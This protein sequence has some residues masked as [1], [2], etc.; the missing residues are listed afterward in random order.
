MSGLL[1]S[2]ALEGDTKLIARMQSWP[3]SVQASLYQ[4]VLY[5]SLKLEAYIKNSKLNG[6]VLKRVSGALA[7]SITSKVEQTAMTVIGVVFSSGDVKYAAIQE[8][9]GTTLAHIIRPKTASVLAWG[10]PKAFAAFVMHP[11]SHMPERSYM[12]S[13]LN[14]MSQEISTGLKQAAV[15]GLMKGAA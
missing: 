10:N 2:V 8:Y 6:Q 9:G 3:T 11:G 5:Y 12:R 4:K 13:A 15:E 14:D 1:F 7:R